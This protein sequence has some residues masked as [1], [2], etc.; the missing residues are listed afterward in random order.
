VKGTSIHLQCLQELLSLETDPEAK[1]GSYKELFFAVPRPEPRN[2]LVLHGESYEEVGEWEQSIQAYQKFIGSVDVDVTGDTLALRDASEKVNFYNSADKSW[3][4]PDL[5]TLVAGARD[6]I[7][8]KNISRLRK[9]QAQVNF[10]Q[11]PWTRRS[12]SAMKR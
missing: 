2:Q 5:N 11:E 8:T 10:F 4:V 9:Y 3:L 6:A 7:T 12:S 1:I